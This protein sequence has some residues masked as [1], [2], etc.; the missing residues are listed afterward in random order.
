MQ[1]LSY[2][3]LGLFLTVISLPVYGQV[4][5]ICHP[6]IQ[7][8]EIDK[9]RL[10]DFYSGDILQWTDG[11]PVVLVDLKEKGKVKNSFYDFLGKSTSRMKSIWMR[12]MLSGESDPPLSIQ[13]EG[14][15]LSL[16]AKTPGAIAF[17]NLNM[18]DDTVKLLAEI[19]FNSE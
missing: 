4:A 10:L 1:F 7:E 14:E 8:N 19:P 18:V 9:V 13:D 16:V 3:K 5:V 6:Q 12:N 2:I 15:I 11:T 17:I